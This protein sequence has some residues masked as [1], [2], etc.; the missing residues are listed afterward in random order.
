MELD[1]ELKQLKE[2]PRLVTQRP[3]MVRLSELRSNG[4]TWGE[5]EQLLINTLIELE[6]RIRVLEESK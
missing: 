5:A 6:Y 1:Q 3:L 4:T 2:D